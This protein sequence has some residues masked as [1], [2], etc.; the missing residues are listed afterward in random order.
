MLKDMITLQLGNQKVGNEHPAFIIAEIGINHQGDIQ[1]ARELIQKAKECGASAVKLQK[2]NLSRILTKEGLEMEYDNRNSF[3]RTYG[4]HKKALEL[5]NSEYEE[6]STFC[7]D[8]D[9]IF[10]ASGWD[11]ESIDFLDELGAPFFKMTSADLTNFPLLTHAANKGKPLIMSTGMADLGI[12]KSAYSLVQSINNQIAILQCTST[13]PADFS[14]INLNVLETYMQEFPDAVIG[15]S[16]HE[17]GI[18][19]PSAAVALGAKIIERHFTL[20]RTMKGG[21]HAASLEPQ[22]FN[23]MVRDIRAIED[24][25]GSSQKEIQESEKPVFKKLAKSIVSAI[26]ITNGIPITIEMLTTKG[27]GTGISPMRMKELIGK[28]SKRDIAQDQVIMEEDIQW[29]I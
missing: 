29:T 22:G 25:M 13:Y 19:I 8:I 6:L 24:A 1:I 4:E 21:D 28:T 10:C 14:E 15:Y 3:G 20:D 17:Q 23:K 18:A 9:I 16:G 11:E 12:V 2:R 27:P 7:N 5:S 26:D